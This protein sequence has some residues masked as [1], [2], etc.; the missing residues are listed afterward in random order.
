M[1][2]DIHITIKFSCF[3][4]QNSNSLQVNLGILHGY[5]F[6]QKANREHAEDVAA[7]EGLSLIN[8]KEVNNTCISWLKMTWVAVAVVVSSRWGKVRPGRISIQHTYVAKLQPN[9]HERSLGDSAGLQRQSEKH[10][11]WAAEAA[12]LL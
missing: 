12:S 2:R 10:H 3:N 11:R 6:T 4:G 1:L 9:H 5:L 7:T 8:W